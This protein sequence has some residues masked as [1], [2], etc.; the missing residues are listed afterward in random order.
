MLSLAYD[1]LKDHLPSK[2]AKIYPDNNI[3]YV[4]NNDK[5]S[6]GNFFSLSKYNIWYICTRDEIINNIQEYYIKLINHLLAEIIDDKP[7]DTKE[8]LSRFYNLSRLREKIENGPLSSNII[9][10]LKI[11]FHREKLLIRTDIFPFKNGNCLELGTGTIR[12][13]KAEDYLIN[14]CNIEYNPKFTYDTKFKYIEKL[15]KTYIN[16]IDMDIKSFLGEL[17]YN[18]VNNSDEAI[19]INIYGSPYGAIIAG[20]LEKFFNI[21]NLETNDQI[22]FDIHNKADKYYFYT[23]RTDSIKYTSNNKYNIRHEEIRKI[24]FLITGNKIALN[25]TKLISSFNKLSV[26]YISCRI[27]QNNKLEIRNQDLNNNYLMAL[28]ITNINYECRVLL[29]IL[30][31][32]NEYFKLTNENIVGVGLKYHN[33]IRFFNITSKL[34]LDTQ[35]L[36]CNLLTGSNSG[37]ISTKIINKC[38]PWLFN[39]STQTG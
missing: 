5:F 24:N 38:Y 2:M 25:N 33:M 9:Y 13:I 16:I 15:Y 37:V 8:K 7:M 32:C 28:L 23:G 19:I 18:I 17:L 14:Y 20:Y 31:Y 26:H 30:A 36:I 21:L 3:L 11:L 6:D 27:D 35:S 4:T 39:L 34:N 1:H 29:L 22:L 10:E 12:K